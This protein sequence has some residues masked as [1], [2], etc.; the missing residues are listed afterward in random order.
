VDVKGGRHTV[1]LRYNFSTCLEGLGE[2][3]RRFEDN[4][5]LDQEYISGS[6]EY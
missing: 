6:T 3:M 1:L 4:W 2:T 5:S